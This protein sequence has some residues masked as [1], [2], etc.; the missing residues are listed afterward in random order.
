MTPGDI[1]LT[2]GAAL[3]AAT[4][5]VRESVHPGTL[6]PRTTYAASHTANVPTRAATTRATT[7]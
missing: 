2:L 5:G 4:V 3:L 1:V 7:K 6:L